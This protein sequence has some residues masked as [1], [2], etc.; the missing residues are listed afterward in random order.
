MESSGSELDVIYKLPGSALGMQKF[1]EVSCSY[2][3]PGSA[4]IFR[5]AGSEAEDI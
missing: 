4:L 3:L 2:E 1:W 5:H